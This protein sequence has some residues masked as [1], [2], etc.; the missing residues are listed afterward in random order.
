VDAVDAAA[1]AS[2]SGDETQVLPTSSTPET[3]SGTGDETQVLPTSST[4]EAPDEEG[5][6]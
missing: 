3:P 1:T 4:P 6:A 2:R 5:R